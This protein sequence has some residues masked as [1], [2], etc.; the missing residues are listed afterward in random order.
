MSDESIAVF[1]SESWKVTVLDIR[2]FHP[3]DRFLIPLLTNLA[4]D[5]IECLQGPLG[6]SGL[7]D[8]Y[9]WYMSEHFHYVYTL[10][11]SQLITKEP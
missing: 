7:H 10:M 2:H 11:Y 8:H 4:G 5:P 6:L 1:Q 3:T 9:S